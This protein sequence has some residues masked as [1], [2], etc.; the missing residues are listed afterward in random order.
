[1]VRLA[2]ERRFD[3]RGR[4][5]GWRNRARSEVSRGWLPPAAALLTGI[6]LVGGARGCLLG[7]AAAFGLGWWQR[8]RR[9]RHGPEP[10][11]EPA[12]TPQLPLAADLLAACLAAGAGPREAA[13]A[14]GASLRG[15]LGR[16]LSRASAELRLGG[17]PAEAWGRVGALPGAARLAKCMERAGTTGAPAVEAVSRVAADCRAEQRRAAGA[18]AGR[19]QVL[20]TA[21]LGL[22]FLPAFLLMSVV[23]MVVGL[24]GGMANA[25]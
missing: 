20:S 8:R 13:E 1:M 18:R 9:S 14:V 10:A 19:A 6:G 22:C 24:S 25:H 12:V 15:R 11:A 2:G 3:P 5:R 4:W 23:P 21:P 7:L 17:E 16:R